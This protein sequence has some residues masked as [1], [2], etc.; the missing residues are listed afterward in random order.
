MAIHR[1][2]PVFIRNMNPVN[3]RCRYSRNAQELINGKRNTFGYQTSTIYGG[4]HT[5]ASNAMRRF[6]TMIIDRTRQ[7]YE[8]CEIRN[9]NIVSTLEILTDIW[10]GQRNIPPNLVAA[11][12]QSIVAIPHIA[13]HE[14][15]NFENETYR[16]QGFEIN[17][18]HGLTMDARYNK[19]ALYQ[20]DSICSCCGNTWTDDNDPEMF[21]W[22]AI[23][24]TLQGEM[25]LLNNFW[26]RKLI[27]FIMQNQYYRLPF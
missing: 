19:Y 8:E 20:V 25:I 18:I 22:D 4:T 7:Q 5:Y 27:Q 9:I 6:E 24:I 13:G 26:K 10:G 16:T 1:D 23:A 2:P 17:A 12:R 14:S 3:L 15:A 11:H 21:T